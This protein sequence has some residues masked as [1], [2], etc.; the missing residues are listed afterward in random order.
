MSSSKQ[1][2]KK[3]FPRWLWILAG[4]IALA[5]SAAPGLFPGRM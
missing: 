4:I 3:S 1:S 5:L 2:S